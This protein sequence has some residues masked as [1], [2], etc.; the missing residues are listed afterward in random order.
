ML[1]E[2]KALP[3]GLYRRYTRRIAQ[4]VEHPTPF[5]G[6]WLRLMV[7]PELEQYD[8]FTEIEIGLPD[9]VIEEIR[10]Q[11]EMDCGEIQRVVRRIGEGSC[12]AVPTGSGPDTE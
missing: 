2:N 9:F 12:E 5:F 3:V 10:E 4:C 6:A 8:D 7:I 11:E 1:L